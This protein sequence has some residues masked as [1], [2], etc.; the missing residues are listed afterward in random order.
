M[1]FSLPPTET[2][3]VILDDPSLCNQTITFAEESIEVNKFIL[4][5][6]STYFRSLWF[7]EFGDRDEN[8]IDFSHLPVHSN[9]FLAFIKSFFG[10]SF[11]LNENNA[12]DFYYLVH[13]FQVDKL[14]LQVEN[15]LNTNLVTWA[16]LK[17]FIKEADERNDLRALEF[18]G[19]FFSKIDDLVI[20]EVMEITTEGLKTLSKYCTS[21]QS[22][23]WFV[24]STVES[25]LNQSFDLN[26]FLNVLNSCSIEALSYS[27]WDEFLF[28][29]L[30]DV[31]EL[32]VD[33]MKF[34]FTR[35]KNLYFD[36]LVKEVS[37]LKEEVSEL[38]LQNFE[39]TTKNSDL[40]SNNSDLNTL[41]TDLT[42]EIHYLKTTISELETNNARLTTDIQNLTTTNSYE[43]AKL[44]QEIEQL[45]KSTTETQLVSQ[46]VPQSKGLD[47]PQLRNILSYNGGHGVRH[48][49]GEDPLLPGN[50]YTWKL[51][52]Q[53]LTG[54]LVVGVI[55]ESKFSVESNC[56]QKGHCSSNCGLVW[57]CLS[58]NKTQWNPGELLEI[59]VNLINHTLTIKSVSNSS[60]NLTG[61]LPRL[62]S[63]NYYPYAY[64][65]YSKH[66]VEIV[67]YT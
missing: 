46:S 52:Y 43:I 22:Q 11:T 28:V 17:P 2:L 30:K 50:E 19:P 12:Y 58:G 9:N 67:E 4:A 40:E 23:S 3:S 59:S 31:E 18:V 38:T 56:Y 54:G 45:K 57:G 64:M 61:T 51:R 13:Y 33:L 21:T 44:K 8:P 27:Q 32:E 49:L 7:L 29:P 60:I 6:L 1:S 15:H 35:V 55:D 41:T 62:S 26:E 47:S 48:I 63:G 10:R 53:G 14:I 24:K 66:V 16:W 37:D 42:T 65:Y 36:S 39:L 5:A 34:L 20:D 25:I